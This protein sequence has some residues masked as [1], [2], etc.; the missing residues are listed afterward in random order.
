MRQYTSGQ[1]Q[2]AYE[3]A[4]T[5]VIDAFESIPIDKEVE[6]GQKEYALPINR[7]GELRMAIDFVLI[8]LM[9]AKQLSAEI[10]EMFPEDRGAIIQEL[11]QKIFKPVLEYVRTH[12]PLSMPEPKPATDPFSASNIQLVEESQ[13]PETHTEHKQPDSHT[14]EKAGITIDP[15]EDIVPRK[16]TPLSA[17]DAET[18]QERIT[19]DPVHHVSYIDTVPK[20]PEAGFGAS[21]QHRQSS[22]A[23]DPYQE[24]IV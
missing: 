20:K 24:P 1:I 16:P 13:A 2:K 15:R 7:A 10:S 11:N 12:E 4:D 8:G 23:S 19:E 18:I 14:L 17:P 6:S 21:S 3:K 22:S 9:S 5:R